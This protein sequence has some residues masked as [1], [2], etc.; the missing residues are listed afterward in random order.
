MQVA[1]VTQFTEI[2][3][4]C[5]TTRL[6]INFQTHRRGSDIPLFLVLA[7]APFLL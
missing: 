5:F 4:Q 1:Y 2:Q 7:E 3:V 6:T